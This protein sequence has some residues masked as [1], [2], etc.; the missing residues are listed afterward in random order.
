MPMHL[1]HGADTNSLA[2]SAW[3]LSP[4]DP[5]CKAVQQ[6]KQLPGC[7]PA[8][9]KTTSTKV[10]LLTWFH[11]S[12]QVH[13]QSICWSMRHPCM[14]VVWVEPVLGGKCDNLVYVRDVIQEVLSPSSLICRL[15]LRE[16]RCILNVF[17]FTKRSAISTCMSHPPNPPPTCIRNEAIL[18]AVIT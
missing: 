17:T 7:F 3:S 12:W 18:K 16:L 4:V 1:L 8:L 2:R 14:D 5:N 11:S 10:S 15:Q 9:F 13:T 6:W